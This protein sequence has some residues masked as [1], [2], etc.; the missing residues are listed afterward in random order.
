MK[1]QLTPTIDDDY[2]IWK[3]S[4]SYEQQDTMLYEITWEVNQNK[5]KCYSE[6]YNKIQRPWKINWFENLNIESFLITLNDQTS[7]GKVCLK[8]RSHSIAYEI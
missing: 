5:I 1:N 6:M 8:P 2:N 3:M 7:Y 4:I